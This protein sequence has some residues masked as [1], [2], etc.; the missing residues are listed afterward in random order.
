MSQPALGDVQELG[1]RVTSVA[2][3]SREEPTMQVH[4]RL[5]EPVAVPY[6][7]PILTHGHRGRR[8]GLTPTADEF[9]Q[10]LNASRRRPVRNV[11]AAGFRVGG[12]VWSIRCLA[13]F[14]VAVIVVVTVTVSVVVA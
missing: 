9:R 13:L 1:G 8:D 14:V 10:A 4:S 6:R 2:R 3:E 7:L 12:S 11:R 5:P